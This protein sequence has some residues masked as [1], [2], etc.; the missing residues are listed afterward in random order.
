MG[1]VSGAASA[2]PSTSGVCGR[3]SCAT[4]YPKRRLR[5]EVNNARVRRIFQVATLM[6]QAPHSATRIVPPSTTGTT[7]PAAFIGTS[8]SDRLGRSFEHSK[9]SFLA[10]LNG[11]MATLPDINC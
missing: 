6:S 1:V 3:L 9:L 11:V 8:P 2:G 7:A 4:A 5:H 10:E